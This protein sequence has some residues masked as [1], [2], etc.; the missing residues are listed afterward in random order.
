KSIRTNDIE[1]VGITSRHHTLFEMLGN[2]SIGDYFKEEAI[3]WAMEILTDPKWYGFDLEKL[4][5]TVHTNDDD[6][7]NYWIKEGVK[8][9][10]IIKLE[11][12]FW[13]IGPG[14]GGPNTEIFYDRGSKFDSRNPKELIKD[15]IEN[16]RVIE[17]WNI[18]FSQ[19]NCNPGIV[20]ISEYEEL[21]QK[22]IDTGLGLE[23]MASVMQDV[24]SNFETDNFIA[25]INHL[26]EITGVPYQS[27]IIAYRVISDHI[28]ALTFAI[29][30][31]V[32]PS[33]AGRGYVIRRILRR[34][35]RYGYNN[36]NQHKPFLSSLVDTVI[37]GAKE[38]YPY[39]LE[40]QDFIKK[41]ITSEE[42]KFFHT[43]DDGVALLDKV[44]NK[45]DSNLL[46]GDV[47]FKL[48]DTYGFPIEL[49]KEI[50]KEKNIIVDEKGYEENLEA[51]RTRARNATAMSGG[52]EKQNPLFKTI[53]VKSEFIGYNKLS[54][55]TTINFITDLENELKKV[56]SGVSFV[57]LDK[58]PF[59][60]ESGGQMADIGTINN[61]QVL[62]V[63]KIAN[64]Q[65]LI[66]LEVIEPLIVGQLVTV[67]V[68][69]K[70]RKKVTDNH[71]VTHL[72]HHVLALQIG[73]H[74]K[75]AGS[76]QDATKT[77]F[78]FTNLEGLTELEITNI[79]IAVNEMINDEL[80]VRITEMKIDDAKALGANALFGEKYGDIV[81]V[82]IM[83][84]SIE[85]CGGTHV[86]NTKEIGS[87]HILT[88]CGIGSGI[89]RIEAISG[90]LVN[91]YINH[92]SINI[93]KELL[94]A[95][96][97]IEN[98]KVPS[99]NELNML[100]LKFNKVIK[101][102]MSEFD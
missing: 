60:A 83:G 38:F 87:F 12:N 91:E 89:R 40:N 29:A 36:L 27:Q 101:Y 69:E 64:G 24:D 7:Y 9:E 81:R 78:D 26:N 79:E 37:H 90:S 62:D 22:N 63:Q 45:L 10:K 100:I 17:I 5:F 50:A 58:C 96:M 21:P 74:V 34:A 72:L 86:T 52:M 61:C 97:S 31:G 73:Q 16:N 14:P 41:V 99:I 56:T 11:E 65:N 76:F 57:I 84:D 51:Q 20:P 8:A 59:Y 82:V 49:T 4:Y 66:K 42:K 13:E 70:E 28:R 92:L 15:D 93:T 32:L 25:I 47:A 23:R 46:P 35:V 18:V 2:F 55:N 88:E 75:Q 68:N 48:Y 80:D 3:N 1:N 102:S 85:L 53:D 6:A 39:L 95:N 77:R 94:I 67:E 43:L 98:K 19:Y 71:S 30:D 33:N 54:I 44:I